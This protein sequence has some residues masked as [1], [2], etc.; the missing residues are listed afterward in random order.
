LLLGLIALAVA[1]GDVRAIFWFVLFAWSGLGSAFG[2]PILLSIYWKGMSRAGAIAG[3]I[4]GFGTTIVWKLWM[5]A[6]VAE[7]TGFSVYELVPAFAVS[8]L[9]TWIFSL[10]LPPGGDRESRA[11]R[12]IRDE[13]A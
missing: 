12:L 7:A 13:T 4:G 10:L 8:L 1:L 6:A 9:L 2:P 5:K 11:E 3:M